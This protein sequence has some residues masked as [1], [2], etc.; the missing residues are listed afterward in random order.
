MKKFSR[1]VS[2]LAYLLLVVANAHPHNPAVG[3]P[4]GVWDRFGAQPDAGTHGGLGS[5]FA[6]LGTQSLGS[7]AVLP[8]RSVPVRIPQFLPSPSQQSQMLYIWG[9]PSPCPTACNWRSHKPCY[10]GGPPPLPC[11]PSH[12]RPPYGQ[13]RSPPPAPP[14]IRPPPPPALPPLPTRPPP[15]PP[16]PQ[17]SYGGG[18][19]PAP[20]PIPHPGP[21][22]R[23]LPQ[24][25]PF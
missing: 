8:F 17:P 16:Q 24:P 13:E 23:L 1:L 25:Q 6:T 4:R 10:R 20:A 15:H 5:G 12:L 3:S 2:S 18:P 19:P 14:R 22:P 7:P 9:K 21:P 11:P